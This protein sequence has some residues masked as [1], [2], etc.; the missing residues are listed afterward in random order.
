MAIIPHTVISS[1]N[2]GSADGNIVITMID[3]IAWFGSAKPAFAVLKKL[4]YSTF[5]DPFC[6]SKGP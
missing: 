4:Q 6:L 3:R 1:T 5:S 2:M